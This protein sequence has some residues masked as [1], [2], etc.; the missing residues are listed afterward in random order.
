ASAASRLL[1]AAAGRA[2]LTALAVLRSWT[3]AAARER[4]EAELLAQLDK[5]SHQST[6]AISMLRNEARA[7]RYRGQRSAAGAAELRA[8]LALAAPWGAWARAAREARHI[9]MLRGQ[10]D[11]ASSQSLL[12]LRSSRGEVRA[13][14]QLGRQS[15]ISA[16]HR[17]ALLDAAAALSAWRVAMSRS[18]RRCRPGEVLLNSGEAARRIQSELQEVRRSSA[19]QL[20]RIGALEQEVSAARKSAAGAVRREALVAAVSRRHELAASRGE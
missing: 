4:G 7:L 10:L 16:T 6:S 3:A 12:A 19:E 11:E 15:A 5:V 9:S 20:E 14:R 13:F 2:Q 17:R 1:A 18:T 8:R